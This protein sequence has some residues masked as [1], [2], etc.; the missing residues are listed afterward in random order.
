M[1]GDGISLLLLLL[2]TELEVLA[3]LD[4]DLVELLAVVALELEDDLLGGLGLLAEDGLCLTSVTL[5][6]HVITALTYLFVF[7]IPIIHHNQQQ[8][9]HQRQQLSW[10][11]ERKKKEERAQTL[12]EDA[13]LSLLVLG[14]LVGSVLFALCAKSVSD[15]RHVHLMEEKKKREKVRTQKKKK[16]NK[17]E[18]VMEKSSG[19]RE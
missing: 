2:G 17:V 12:S 6:L 1:L 14:D 4:G 9:Y 8:K 18:V 16:K 11:G 3:A 10:G 13:L 5:L 7:F 15:L 19:E